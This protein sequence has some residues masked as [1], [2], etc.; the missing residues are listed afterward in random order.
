MRILYVVP[1]VP[2]RIRTRPFNFIRRLSREHEVWVLC[3]ASND[4]DR[5]SQSELRQY[6]Q[7][8]EV[9]ELPRWKS[10]LNCLAA[11]FSLRP[12][13]YAYFYSPQLCRRVREMV[14]GQE[15]DLL[16]VEHLKSVPMVRGVI[17]AIPTVFDAVDC[18]SMFE[19]R[20]RKVVTNP[21]LKLFFW[22]EWK[23]MVLG[24]TQACVDFDRIAISS[25]I[26]RESYPAPAALK[27]RLHVVRNGV[28]LDYFDF[29]KVEP[30]EDVL[31]FC[32]KL[33][34]FANADAA[35]HFAQ[36]IWPYVLKR[37]PNL[38]L[39]IVGSRPPRK[40][41]QLDGKNSI[42][43]VGSVPDVRPFLRRARV[44]LCPVRVRAG[45][46]FKILE[47]MALGVPVIATRICCPGLDVEPGKHLLVA[48]T[49]EEFV[50]A[51]GQILDNCSLRDG[52]VHAGRE[53]V[54]THHDWDLSVVELV[55]IYNEARE[56][57][58]GV[59]NEEFAVL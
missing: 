13:R 51:V 29:G 28:D 6:C 41:K 11:L 15:L 38:K 20:R 26:D 34:Y 24:E 58:V 43:V 19:A 22:T 16:H 12:L 31:V 7:S 59:H 18:V 50:S 32:A 10:F 5:R 56:D 4:S 35:V 14:N 23:K 47:A 21:L 30:Q 46:Q 27:K 53:Y 52:L 42:R 48:D 45:I 39:E 40:V 1:N 57:F 54:E 49:A 8:V 55:K 3:L 37:R 25:E 17:G 36:F 44:A 9:L 2:S 33:D